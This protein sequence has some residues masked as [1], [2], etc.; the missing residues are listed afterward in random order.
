MQLYTI[1][2]GKNA[3][4]NRLSTLVISRSSSSQLRRYNVCIYIHVHIYL[5]CRVIKLL[6]TQ[7]AEDFFYIALIQ[8]SHRLF[9]GKLKSGGWILSD[10]FWLAFYIYIKPFRI[11]CNVIPVYV[12]ILL[13]YLLLNLYIELDKISL[14]SSF[15]ISGF[16]YLF[17]SF[18]HSFFLCP[19]KLDFAFEATVGLIHLSL[20]I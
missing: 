16:I 10:I 5:E 17:F 6:I 14:L 20:E 11:W 3:E 4:E 8:F 1:M 9:Q 7:S 12:I 13:L 18:F 15:F 2:I 19:Q